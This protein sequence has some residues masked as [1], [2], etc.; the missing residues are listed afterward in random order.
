MK[1]I[2]LFIGIFLISLTLVSALPT[3]YNPFSGRLDYY[4]LNNNGTGIFNID[5]DWLFGVNG[6]LTFNESQADDRWINKLGD[7]FEQNILQFNFSF[8][9]NSLPFAENVGSFIVKNLNK[10]GATSISAHNDIGTSVS[11][12]TSGTNFFPGLGIDD[13]V[14]VAATGSDLLLAVREPGR[15]IIFQ[16]INSSGSVIDTLIV[17]SDGNVLAK[18]DIFLKDSNK[19]IRTL[20][21]DGGSS[22]V[23]QSTGQLVA[24]GFPFIRQAIDTSGDRIVTSADQNGN[25]NS[26]SFEMNTFGPVS[27]DWLLHTGMGADLDNITFLFN[28]TSYLQYCDYLQDNKSLIPEGCQY[29]ADTQGRLVPLLHGGDLEI[30]RTATIHEGLLL[31]EDFNYITRQGNDINVFN[32][33]LHLQTPV[34]FESGFSQGDSFTINSN[35]FEGG[36][37]PFIND[38]GN[39]IDWITISN[40]LCDDGRCA[41]AQGNGGTVIMSIVF[42]TL[43]VNSPSINFVYSLLNLIG[44]DEFTVVVNN[45]TGSGDVEIFS[46]SGTVDKVS[47]NIELTENFWN[48]SQ[49]NLTVTCAASQITRF[50]YFDTFKVNGTIM[51]D[52]T[53]NVSGFNSVI[54]MSEGTIG[55]DG[56]PSIGIYYDAPNDT[57]FIRAPNVNITGFTGGGG[58]GGVSGSGTA[59]NIPKWSGSTSLTNSIMSESGGIITIAGDVIA[60]NFKGLFNWTTISDFLSFDGATLTFNET[61][62]NQTISLEGILL[63]FNSTF[64]ETYNNLN[65]SRWDSDGE[66]ISYSLGNVG[67]GTDTPNQL[68]DVRGNINSSLVIY[69]LGGITDA[70]NSGSWADAYNLRIE[71][72]GKGLTYTANINDLSLNINTNDFEFSGADQLQLTATYK[73]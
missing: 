68:L 60:N 18:G 61:K 11:L 26:F 10:S 8:S 31:F 14:G 56:F 55:S 9:N 34:T 46:D 64:N 35:N 50:C 70:H 57:L 47:Q 19:S 28:A 24:G 42:S 48:Q 33:S 44:A 72:Y 27:K 37:S 49:I 32:A 20:T 22:L 53:Q 21:V 59:G 3:I 5:N 65:S 69:A 38:P 51:S 13:S 6:T 58:G 4:G 45:N 29:F 2:S 52:S 66:N 73:S 36:I 54:T 12:F 63:G 15:N 17:Q 67:I 71:T 1:K 62:L 41:E 40:T 30:H 43:D 25:N 7:S 16:I 23:L 39:I